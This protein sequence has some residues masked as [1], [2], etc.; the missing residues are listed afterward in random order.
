MF[1]IPLPHHLEEPRPP[2]SP[3]SS[4]VGPVSERD[5]DTVTDGISAGGGASL[6]IKQGSNRSKAA[7][8]HLG[9]HGRSLVGCR[10]IESREGSLEPLIQHE[11]TAGMRINLAKKAVQAASGTQVLEVEQD[12]LRVGAQRGQSSGRRGT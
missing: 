2:S 10:A 4:L 12:D 8:T 6:A 11:T 9:L 3:K 7:A 5:A 1:N